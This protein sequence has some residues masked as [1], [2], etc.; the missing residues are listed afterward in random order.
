MTKITKETLQSLLVYVGKN[1]VLSMIKKYALTITL[2]LI[3]VAISST[4]ALAQ[5]SSTMLFADLIAKG[6]EIFN[7]MRDIIYVVAGF[8]II[9]VSVGGFFGQINWK[10]LSA[11]IIALMVIGVT[12]SILNFIVGGPSQTGITDTLK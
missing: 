4:N 5:E 7:G 11:I 6:A 12:G 3:F 1:K 10:W 9:G 2:T 8:G